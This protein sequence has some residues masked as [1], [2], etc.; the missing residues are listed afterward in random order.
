MKKLAASVVASLALGAAVIAPA[1]T[2]AA[3]GKTDAVV[4]MGDSFI[5]GEGGRWNGN[6]NDGFDPDRDGTDRAH[7]SSWWGGW[8]YDYTAVY[9][10]SYG[11]GCNRSDVSE[12][13]SS[14]IGAAHINI[15]CSGATTDN[16]IRAASGGS[17][18][19]G[20]AP[21]AD[22]LAGIVA[23]YDVTM[24][25]L[26]IGGNDLGFADKLTSCITAFST[27]GAPCNTAEQ[28]AVDAELPGVA[29]A[30]SGAVAEIKAAMAAAGDTNYRLVL[31]SYPSPVPRAS[32]M[33]YPES[34]WS[35]LT[36]GGCPFWD[37]DADWARDSL[38]GQID[39]ALAQV[40]E[41]QSVDFLSLADA[42]EDREVCSSSVT[43]VNG[44][45]DTPR[46]DRHEWVR[47]LTSGAVQG[48]LQE[49]LHP[50]A[51]GQVALGDC[52][53]MVHAAGSGDYRC[54]RSGSTA[55]QMSIVSI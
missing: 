27:G 54:V 33:R 53:G 43:L 18:F 45:N 32:E 7:R 47:F 49:S 17:W 28:A 26:S 13:R 12:V 2:A 52:L 24:I 16:I 29:A 25:V 51:F 10:G 14:G 23:G 48:Q 37:A 3:W 19:K 11:N 15:A 21:Q 34:G 44:D 35:R 41:A 42:F 5:S 1:T 4:T 6:S 30:V 55:T 36:V 20:E 38:V 8:W 22:Q 9:P 40:A 50:N 46:S 39:T 31:Q